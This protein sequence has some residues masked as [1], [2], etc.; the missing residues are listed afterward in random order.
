M[1][2][3]IQTIYLLLSAVLA[4]LVFAVDINVIQTVSEKYVFKVLGVFDSAGIYFIKT[5][6][7]AIVLIFIVLIN[8]FAIFMFKK[9]KLQI[10][11]NILAMVFCIAFIALV[12]YYNYQV[13]Q[14]MQG[15]F[16]FA[17]GVVLPLFSLIF[18][19]LANKRIK[20]DEA[21]VRS[22]DRIR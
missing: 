20:K 12:F 8:L 15:T 19:L 4:G 11:L 2:Q 9:R 5:N 6:P 13:M 3:R 16:V 22:V 14:A 7:L 10:K 17:A 21:L 1:I 18:L